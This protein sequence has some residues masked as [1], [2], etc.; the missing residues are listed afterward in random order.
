MM[1]I[2][3]GDIPRHQITQK[4]LRLK[5]LN[6]IMTK[7]AWHDYTQLEAWSNPHPN[8]P[9][10]QPLAA[11]TGHPEQYFRNTRRDHADKRRLEAPTLTHSPFQPFPYIKTL[12]NPRLVSN[13]IRIRSQNSYIP[14]QIP[15]VRKGTKHGGKG[16]YLR[17][18]FAE[19]FC[20][21]CIPLQTGW[22]LARPLPGSAIGSE[23]HLLLHCT[24]RDTDEIRIQSFINIR[25]KV[26][27][28]VETTQA[29]RE[30]WYHLPD[31]A[32]LQ[33]LLACTLQ[34][35]WGL[36]KKEEKTWFQEFEPL[37]H[38]IVTDLLKFGTIY[39][40]DLRAYYQ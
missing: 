10:A 40:Q 3:Q 6:H 19:R 35:Q 33:T 29:L 39:R 18:K 37:L 26:A 2:T 23:E 24:H 25:D 38:D 8:A 27:D 32:K 20:P 11:A 1:D 4:T 17:I 30:P 31:S 36:L 16:T 34:S 12:E 14:T 22:G 13:L 5:W 15:S 9:G 21:A 7:L 28:L